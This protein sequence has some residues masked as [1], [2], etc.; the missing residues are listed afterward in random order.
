MTI[1]RCLNDKGFGN[2]KCAE[3]PD[4]SEQQKEDSIFTDAVCKLDKETCGKYVKLEDYT[5][6][7]APWLEH[8]NFV[9]TLI[10]T[11]SEE[12]VNGG[13]SK[14]AKTKKSE[15]EIQQGSMF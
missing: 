10:P 4:Y 2:A 9:E 13:K 5:D 15:A 8:A 14:S 3:T 1:N 12:K 6:L 11:K 7:K